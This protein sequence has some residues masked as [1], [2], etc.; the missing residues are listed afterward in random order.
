PAAKLMPVPL[1]GWLTS[2]ASGWSVGESP[3]D[4]KPGELAPALGM[5][6]AKLMAA[7]WWIPPKPRPKPPSPLAAAPGGVVVVK[8]SNVPLPDPRIR[9]PLDV[10]AGAPPACQIPP[11]SPFGVV[12][13]TVT[14]F[15]VFASNPMSQPWYGSISPSE[16]EPVKTT[17]S[18]CP[19]T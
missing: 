19:G 18:G 16:A 6:A 1:S 4:N 10:T 13:K 3:L 8:A 9:S 2:G 7:L 5:E 11:K 14:I 17:P 15:R 12:L